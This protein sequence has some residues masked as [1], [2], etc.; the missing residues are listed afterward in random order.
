MAADFI[1]L[2][3]NDLPYALAGTLKKIFD[4]KYWETLEGKSDS[5]PLFT[6]AEYLSAE[7]KIVQ[8]KFFVSLQLTI[9]PMN[10]LKQLRLISSV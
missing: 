7:Q 10:C 9:L 8:D 3:S 2:G 6:P 5:F 1:Y 4:Y